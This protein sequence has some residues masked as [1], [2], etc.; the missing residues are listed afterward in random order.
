M[1]DFRHKEFSEK[2]RQLKNAR[3][4]SVVPFNTRIQTR[5]FKHVSYTDQS[6]PYPRCPVQTREPLKWKSP[7]RIG[8][9]AIAGETRYEGCGTLLGAF[10]VVADQ[11]YSK[12]MCGLTGSDIPHA[13]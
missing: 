7:P 11:A 8:L 12:T 6:T 9:D 4:K 1:D 5:K 2:E 10:S 13:V 3:R